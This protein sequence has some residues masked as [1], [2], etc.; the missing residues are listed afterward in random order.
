LPVSGLLRTRA[1]FDGLASRP[2]NDNPFPGYCA[3][4]RTFTV[5]H[6]APGTIT[7][8]P[9]AALPQAG[10]WDTLAWKSMAGTAPDGHP[11]HSALD[12]HP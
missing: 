9:A 10:A 4:E 5:L 8:F 2:G 12:F 3:A 11:V 7:R 6:P 1:N